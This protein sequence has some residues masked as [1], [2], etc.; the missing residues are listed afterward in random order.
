[1]TER[2]SYYDERSGGTGWGWILA[3]GA[4]LILIGFLALVNPMTTGVATGFLVAMLLLLYAVGAI[5]SGFSTFS[6][7]GRW[8]EILLGVMALTASIILF[9]R[10]VQGAL[11]LVWAIGFWLALS[12]LLQILGAARLAVDRGW[13]LFLGLVDLVLGGLL[14]FADP[15]TGL[16]F[17]ALMVGISFLF[18]GLFLVMLAFG[19]RRLTRSL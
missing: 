12:G 6:T 8:I 17:L 10:P 2:P 16:A 19:L 18:K 4:F 15:A 11:S 5:A 13:R 3:Y 9:T 1:M 14:L 7:R